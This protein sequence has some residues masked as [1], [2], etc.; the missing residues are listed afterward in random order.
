MTN[1]PTTD[2][3]QYLLDIAHNNAIAC[4]YRTAFERGFLSKEDAAIGMAKM[5]IAECEHLREQLKAALMRQSP[6][7]I[8]IT[9][10]QQRLDEIKA[11]FTGK[12]STQEK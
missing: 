3:W 6:P 8:M 9:V 10:D 12:N 2:D 11:Q 5:A 1:K 7:P 4:Y